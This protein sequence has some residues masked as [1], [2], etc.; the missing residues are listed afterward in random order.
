[1]ASRREQVLAAVKTLLAGALPN[2]DVKRNQ[3]KAER[4]G[5]GGSVIIRDGEPG[6]PEVDLSPLRYH[7]MH[8]IPL[9]IAVYESATLTREER[10]DQVLSAIGGAVEGD[11]TLGGLCEY[12]EAEAPSTDDLEVMGALAGRWADAAIVAHYTTPSPL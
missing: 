1:M 4:I 10:L 2:A 8:R 12:L 9:E 3:A 6:E 5:P 7:Y 11:R